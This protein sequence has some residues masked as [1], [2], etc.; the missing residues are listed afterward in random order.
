MK[1]LLS[2]SLLFFVLSCSHS[3]S[4][5]PKSAMEERI[6]W[7]EE[8]K[9]LKLDPTLSRSSK[10]RFQMAYTPIDSA[11]LGETI[12]Y[13]TEQYYYP[14]SLVK[15]PLAML[16]LEVLE[17][18]GIPLDA[19]IVFDTVDACG[20]VRFVEVSREK[21]SFQ[22]L[23]KELIV[24]SDNQFYNMLYHFLTP[25]YINRRLHEMGFEGT[26][27]YRAFTGCDRVGQ[28]HTY[29]YKI[30][31]LNGKELMAS[32]G[33]TMDSTVLEERY[34]SSEERMFGSRHENDEGDIVDGP[35][36]LNYS[37]EIPMREMHEMVLRMIRP[38]AF[39]PSQRW[40]VSDGSLR[41]MLDY[42]SAYPSEIPTSYRNFRSMEDTVYKYAYLRNE[43]GR[44]ERSVSKLGLSYGFASEVAWI[45]IPGSEQSF[46]LT[47]SIYVN[48]NDIVNDG[49]YEYDEVARPF[50]AE[51][52]KQIAAWQLQQIDG[53]DVED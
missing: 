19:Y 20:S 10:Y 26:N 14:A 7:P 45:T 12:T 2:I 23:F 6:E 27:I 13:G 50:A 41:F 3:Q 34:H 5:N 18:K 48:A 33:K 43:K 9:G 49:E 15:I 25:E 36:D 37:I 17:E 44:R 8:L 31:G 1:I 40:K 28:L 30:Y 42:M 21:I 35:F 16:A 32:P 4:D 51:L 47:Y 53:T 52:A 24:V 39:E 29:P 22:Q 38:E 11:G 46:L